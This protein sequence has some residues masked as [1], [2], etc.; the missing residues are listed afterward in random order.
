M[1][2]RGSCA[3]PSGSGS[4]RR[5]TFWMSPGKRLCKRHWAL[6]VTDEILAT[7]WRRR[8]SIREYWVE[9]FFKANLLYEYFDVVAAVEVI[10]HVRENQEF[11]DKAQQFLKPGELCT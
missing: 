3:T 11:V 10:E 4:V 2:R 6:G 8:S 1:W 9:D 5:C 7:L